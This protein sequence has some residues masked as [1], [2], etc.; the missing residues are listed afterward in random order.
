VFVSR[1]NDVP[2]P[3]FVVGITVAIAVLLKYVPQALQEAALNELEATGQHIVH[4][5][6]L[7]EPPGDADPPR[8]RANP[9]TSLIDG[10]DGSPRREEPARPFIRATYQ[11]LEAAAGVPG[12]QRLGV[13]QLWNLR[14]P[15]I[16]WLL[17]RPTGHRDTNTKRIVSW[18]YRLGFGGCFVGAL[19]PLLYPSRLALDVW[20]LAETTEADEIQGEVMRSAD[21]A[22]FICRKFAIR[23]LVLVTGHLDVPARQDFERW[24]QTFRVPLRFHCVGLTEFGWPEAPAVPGRSRLPD[25]VDLHRWRFPREPRPRFGLHKVVMPAMVEAGASA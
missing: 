5:P 17:L 9:Q 3:G 25:T 10:H 15:M 6:R 16:Y 8:R 13:S 18:S 19:Y 24:I 14:Q 22:T 20:R 4:T 21:H 11:S 23:R 12:G 1:K 2:D 7:K